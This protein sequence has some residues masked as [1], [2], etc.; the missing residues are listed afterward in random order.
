MKYTQKHHRMPIVVHFCPIIGTLI[1][2]ILPFSI[3]RTFCNRSITTCS[4]ISAEQK[5]SEEKAKGVAAVWG[6]EFIQFLATLQI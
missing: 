5:D 6:K 2:L 1:D 4:V 3:C